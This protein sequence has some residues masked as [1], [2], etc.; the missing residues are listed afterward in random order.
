MVILN[1]PSQAQPTVAEANSVPS[2]NGVMDA[3]K[4]FFLC[5]LAAG[6]LDA[7]SAKLAGISRLRTPKE[8]DK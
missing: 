4:E 8:Q 2:P 5:S 1:T 6:I 3:Q 7:E